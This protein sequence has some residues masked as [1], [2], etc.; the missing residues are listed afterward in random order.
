MLQSVQGHP[1]LKLWT[2]VSCTLS[3]LIFI[4]IQSISAIKNTVFVGSGIDR[5]GLVLLGERYG[6]NNL[7]FIILCLHYLRYEWINFSYALFWCSIQSQSLMQEPSCQACLE[8]LVIYTTSFLVVFWY[9][10]TFSIYFLPSALL[11]NHSCLLMNCNLYTTVTLVM[12][13][14]SW[15]I[16]WEYYIL[17]LICRWIWVPL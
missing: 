16:S 8:F 3:V 13:F 1:L 12:L 14:C 6:N 15:R 4:I 11:V 17:I 7:Q 10:Y 2:M 9:A 5:D